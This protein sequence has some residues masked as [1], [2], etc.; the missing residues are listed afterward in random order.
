MVTAFGARESKLT[1][2]DFYSDQLMS[3]KMSLSFCFLL[4][5]FS[6]PTL[7]ET[8]L[9]TSFQVVSLLTGSMAKVKV[10]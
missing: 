9:E 10:K 4:S 2:R 7:T 5:L 8:Q 1:E 6:R 3:L